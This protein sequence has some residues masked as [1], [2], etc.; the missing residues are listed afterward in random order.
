ME[1]YVGT[2]VIE[3]SPMTRGDYNNYRGWQIPEDEN[4]EDAGYL[5]KYSDGYVSWSPAYAFEESY[6][7]YD[8]NKLPATAVGMM[9]EDYRERFKAEY[10]QLTIRI[11]GLKGMLKKWDEGTLSFEPTCPR[12]IYDLQLKVMSEYIA[13]LE[14][15]AVMEDVDLMI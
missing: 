7:E 9:S 13:V 1:K 6:R 10:K 2:K 14:A 5:V 8:E 12:S 4:P 3:A 11:E 15:R